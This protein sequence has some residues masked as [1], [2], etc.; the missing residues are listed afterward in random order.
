ML[1]DKVL[2]GWNEG[3]IGMRKGGSRLLRVPP[4]L[5]Y[6]DR[7]I[8]DVIPPQATLLFVIELIDLN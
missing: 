1:L 8:E 2:Q 3:V 5:A 7:N 6:G 4:V